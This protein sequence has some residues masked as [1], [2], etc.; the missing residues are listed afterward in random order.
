MSTDTTLSTDTSQGSTPRPGAPVWLELTTDDVAAAQNFYSELFG[1][2]FSE[3]HPELGDYI[4]IKADG[5]SLGGLMSS[6]G[7]ECPEGAEIPNSWDVYLAV[8]KADTAVELAQ[9]AGARVLTGP[10]D[11]GDSGRFAMLMDP[12]GAPIGI[13]QAT[14]FSGLSV[15]GAVGTPVWFEAMSMDFDAALPFYRDVLSWDISWMGPEGGSDEFRYVTHGSAEAAVAGLCDAEK[16][17]PADTPSFWRVYFAVE[18]TDAAV[19]RVEGLGGQLISEAVSDS[20]F[21]R[22]ATVA[23]PTGATFLINQEPAAPQP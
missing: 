1:W 6:A 16:F 4:E 19:S 20:P 9:S 11:A 14:G 3:P 10:H 8:P 5:S 23:D 15:T 21:G 12:A 7:M 2:S 17:F 22:F 13:W 18:D